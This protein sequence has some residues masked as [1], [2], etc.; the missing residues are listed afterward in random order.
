MVGSANQ[1]GVAEEEDAHCHS[2]VGV[3]TQMNLGRL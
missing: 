2:P 3:G 1:L